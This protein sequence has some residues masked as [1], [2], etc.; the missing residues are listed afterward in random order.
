M[1]LLTL[2]FKSQQL[3]LLL[4]LSLLLMLLQLPLPGQALDL[5]RNDRYEGFPGERPR[6][7]KRH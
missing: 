2:G 5:V 7:L 1:S 6:F 4:L 3:L